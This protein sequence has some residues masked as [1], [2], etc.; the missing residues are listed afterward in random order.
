MVVLELRLHDDEEIDKTTETTI[1]QLPGMHA[2]SPPNIPAEML[3]DR[4]EQTLSQ[5][6]SQWQIITGKKNTKR[7]EDQY[8]KA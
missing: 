2:E 1:E 5:N 3:S 4:H 7:M 6:D 8:L